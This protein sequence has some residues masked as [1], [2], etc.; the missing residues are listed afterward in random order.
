MSVISDQPSGQQLPYL[1]ELTIYSECTI[2][3]RV[4]RMARQIFEEQKTP[5]CLHLSLSVGNNQILSEHYKNFSN[6]YCTNN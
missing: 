6:I 2:Q 1:I 5:S 4:T 3:S